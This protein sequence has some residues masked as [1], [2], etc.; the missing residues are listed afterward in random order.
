[1]GHLRRCGCVLLLHFADLCLA[2]DLFPVPEQLHRDGFSHRRRGDDPGKI[3]RIADRLAVEV[4]DD[5]PLLDPRLVGRSARN[6][7]RDEGAFAFL[8]SE[9]LGQ[10]RGHILDG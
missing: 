7:L 10:F 3:L 9:R 5:I 1:M 2:L 8:E 4:H 6:H